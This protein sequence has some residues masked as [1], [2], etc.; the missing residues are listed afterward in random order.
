MHRHRVVM[1]K[2]YFRQR[3]ADE[4]VTHQPRKINIQLSLEVYRCFRTRQCAGSRRNL[5][6]MHGDIAAPNIKDMVITQA[7]YDRYELG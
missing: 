2:H 4:P 3:T 1:A 5:L 7:D 6:K